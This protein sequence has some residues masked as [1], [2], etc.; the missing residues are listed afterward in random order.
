MQRHGNWIIFVLATAVASQFYFMYTNLKLVRTELDVLRPTLDQAQLKIQD[1]EKKDA[2]SLK[3]LQETLSK[4][5]AVEKTGTENSQKLKDAQQKIQTIEKTA[6]TSVTTEASQPNP[7][8]AALKTKV[9]AIAAA[10]E[11]SKQAQNAIANV[12]V[13]HERLESFLTMRNVPAGK[14][15]QLFYII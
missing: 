4:I 5:Q 15:L 6:S 3:Q 9:D 2:E 7:D 14:F 10:S 8:F 13:D 12:L 1:L 11:A